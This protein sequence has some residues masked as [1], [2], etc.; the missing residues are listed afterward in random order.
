M[1]FG[2]CEYWLVED[3]FSEKTAVCILR[4][5]VLRWKSEG[6]DLWRVSGG[7]SDGLLQDEDSMLL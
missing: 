5:E 6:P 3:N 4:D 1:F 2:F 7:K